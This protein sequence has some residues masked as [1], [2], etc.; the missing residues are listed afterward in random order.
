MGVKKSTTNK[1]MGRKTKFDYTSK[2]F[3][4]RLFELAKK[5]YTDREITRTIG[6]NET[7]FYEF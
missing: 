6:M 4:S 7:Y 5:S 1:K 2:E 3:L